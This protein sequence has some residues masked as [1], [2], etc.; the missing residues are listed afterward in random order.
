MELMGVCSCYGHDS[1]MRMD[2]SPWIGIIFMEKHDP[3]VLCN[4]YQSIPDCSF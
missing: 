1:T 4:I 2:I 3:Q